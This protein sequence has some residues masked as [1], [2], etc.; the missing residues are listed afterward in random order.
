M[1]MQD[2]VA[3]LL[4]QIR[5]AQMVRMGRITLPSSKLKCAI[6]EVLKNEGYISDYKVSEDSKPKLEIGLRYLDDGTPVIETIQR[7][8]RP[9]L[10]KYVGRGEIPRIQNGLGIAILSTNQGVI[11]DKAARKLGIGGETLCTVF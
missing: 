10:R 11:T 7:A 3:D 1:T 9:G 6:C 8:S 4:T 2:P 5:N